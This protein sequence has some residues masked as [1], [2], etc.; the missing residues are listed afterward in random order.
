MTASHSSSWLASADYSMECPPV[1]FQSGRHFCWEGLN[2]GPSGMKDKQDVLVE[3]VGTQKESQE[4]WTQITMKSAY[5][6]M[7]HNTAGRSLEVHASLAFL[8][9]SLDGWKQVQQPE[10]SKCPALRSS[11]V[12]NIGFKVNKT[13]QLWHTLKD[14]RGI[15][16]F[17]RE[18]QWNSMKFFGIKRKWEF[19]TKKR[20]LLQGAVG[21]WATQQLGSEGLG[22][23]FN[24]KSLV[25]KEK[26]R[27]L[28]RR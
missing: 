11:L 28:A 15:P 1:M 17:L 12:P 4:T 8:S 20:S 25:H 16:A 2:Q 18:Y 5:R 14:F 13:K 7:V 19:C 22:R 23:H 27:R 9:F 6:G 10:S 21:K 24:Q 3:E 26:V